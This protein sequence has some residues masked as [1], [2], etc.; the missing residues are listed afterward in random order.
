MTPIE[1]KAIN[2]LTAYKKRVGI[3]NVSLTGA[4]AELLKSGIGFYDQSTQAVIEK[5]APEKEA[6]K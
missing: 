2:V 4:I 3:F 1:Q 5:T 6:E